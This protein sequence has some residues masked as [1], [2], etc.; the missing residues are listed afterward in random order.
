MAK[1]EALVVHPTC[2]ASY[3]WHI[4]GGAGRF[5]YCT[6]CS[7]VANLCIFA[8]FD[9]V[10]ELSESEELRDLQL[11]LAIRRVCVAVEV[12]TPWLRSGKSSVCSDFCVF[13]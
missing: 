13:E 8:T 7:D 2:S 10:Y 4:S 6:F 5:V 3:K 9:I 1:L 11:S 12:L